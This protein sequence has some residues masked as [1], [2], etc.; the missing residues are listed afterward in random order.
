MTIE[1]KLD[2]DRTYRNFASMASYNS[3]LN[4]EQVNYLFESHGN[5][6]Y[7]HGH[8]RTIIAEAIT[9]DTFKVYTKTF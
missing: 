5:D 3:I 2:A 9:I 1:Q 8:L 4:K 7:C 6:I